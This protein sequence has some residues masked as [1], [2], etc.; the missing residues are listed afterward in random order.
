MSDIRI[1]VL[2][3]DYSNNDVYVNVLNYLSRKAYLG[4]Y[5]F[6]PNFSI[7]ITEQFQLCEYFSNANSQQKLWHFCVTFAQ[8]WNHTALLEMAVWIA[9]TFSN[10]YQIM[11][12]LDLERGGKPDIPHLHFCVNAFSY[13]PNSTPL[14]KEEMQWRMEWIQQEL[15]TKCSPC[16]VT[17]Q[18]QGKRQ[19]RA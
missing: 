19:R 6:S 10:E 8:S 5:G 1:E 17:L 3:G 16:S 4:G 9:S 14:S 7:C 12:A 11:Y 2:S 15:S 18:F 13:H